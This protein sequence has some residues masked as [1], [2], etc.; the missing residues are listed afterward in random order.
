MIPTFPLDM[1]ERGQHELT[2]SKEWEAVPHVEGHH[3][4][5]AQES[6]AAFRL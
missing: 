6:M 4:G 3:A 1:E 5:N 2:P